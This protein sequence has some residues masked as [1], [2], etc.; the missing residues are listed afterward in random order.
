MRAEDAL[1]MFE[2]A[3]DLG[4]RNG[5]TVARQYGLRRD[6]V[7]QFGEQTL[8]ERQPLRRRLEHEAGPFGGRI[9]PI[10][11]GNALQ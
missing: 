7:F 4:R 8:F 11:H 5:R 9:E 6:R 1:A 10:V 2:M 3:G